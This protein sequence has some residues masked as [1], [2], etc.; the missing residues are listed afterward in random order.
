MEYKEEYD[1]FI[2]DFNILLSK[3]EKN[4][5]EIS[6]KVDEFCVEKK[7][8]FKADYDWVSPYTITKDFTICVMAHGKKPERALCV[9]NVANGTFKRLK[10][11]YKNT[12][13]HPDPILRIEPNLLQLASTKRGFWVALKET[14]GPDAFTIYDLKSKND[15]LMQLY[16]KYVKFMDTSPFSGKERKLAY[17]EQFD[18]LR[19]PN[20]SWVNKSVNK[21]KVKDSSYS[22]KRPKLKTNFDNEKKIRICDLVKGEVEIIP[23]QESDIAPKD[24]QTFET[25]IIDVKLEMANLNS[26][27]NDFDSIQGDNGSDD[28]I[29]GIMMKSD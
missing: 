26:E 17:I 12:F 25:D 7:K 15:Q 10:P 29:F 21:S 3:P 28:D 14:C 24:H 6:S 27:E 22:K 11:H 23:Y 19:Y 8:F 1:K 9:I 2:V 18:I 20:E 13:R 16:N 4:W 5:K